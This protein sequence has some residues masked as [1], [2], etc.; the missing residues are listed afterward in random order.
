MANENTNTQ[1]ERRGVRTICDAY[2]AGDPPPLL[3]GTGHLHETVP[4]THTLL[5]WHRLQF[6]ARHSS[7]LSLCAMTCYLQYLIL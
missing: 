2:G 7:H 3:V 6:S 5:L 1:Q 4:D